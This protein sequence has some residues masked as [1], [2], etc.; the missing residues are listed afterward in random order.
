MLASHSGSE[1]A[2]GQKRVLDFCP[3]RVRQDAQDRS[4]PVLL[5]ERYVVEIQRAGDEHTV[6]RRKDHLS[7]EAA[8]RSGRWHHDDLAQ[9]ISNLASRQD[10]GLADA[11]PD[12]ETCTSG[13]RLGSPEF[14]PTLCVPRELLVVIREFVIPWWKRTVRSGVA[15]GP[16]A[17][18]ANQTCAL[19]QSQ[20]LDE[21]D[22]FVGG[23]GLSPHHS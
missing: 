2:S 3:S 23:Q 21:R 6:I 22:N 1:A 7:R 17:D 19:G 18:Q 8:D 16:C 5:R 13:S 14:L 12:T 20:V 11:C 9:R 10:S 4:D 15:F